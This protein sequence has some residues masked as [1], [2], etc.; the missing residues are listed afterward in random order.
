MEELMLKHV[1]LPL[2]GSD[3]A[4]RAVDYAR[5]ITDPYE[6][7]I[8]LLSVVDVPESVTMM[9]AP[10][11]IVGFDNHDVISDKL[12]PDANQYLE[13]IEESLRQDGFTVDTAVIID[14]PALAIIEKAEKLNVDAIVMS[15]HGRT[16]FSRFLFGSVAQKV[17]GSVDC[18]VF[19]VPVRGKNRQGD[20]N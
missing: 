11:G 15:T 3:V 4:E 18:P 2:D 6:G 16:G 12:V 17:L 9:Y 20:L 1:L 8:T 5:S 19:I 10:G 7:K 14:D 13:K